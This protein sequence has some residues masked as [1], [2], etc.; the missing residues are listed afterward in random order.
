MTPLAKRHPY[1]GLPDYQFWKNEPGITDP[2]LFDPINTTSFSIDPRDAIVTAGSCFAQHVARYLSASGFNF[3]VT[4]KCHPIFPAEVAAANNFNIFSAR[5]GNIY[6]V[7]QL[8]QLILRA[9][10]EFEPAEHAWKRSDGCFLDPFRPQI[11]RGGYVNLQELEA[12]RASHLRAVR[13]AFEQMAVF[14]FTL[15]LTETWFDRRDGAVFPLAPGV[16]GG[17][18]D[19]ERFAFQ[20][21]TVSEV[22]DDLQWCIDRIRTLNPRCRFIV[23]VS[24]VPLNATA[25]DRHVVL[26]TTLS[27]S[28]LRVAAEQVC[29][30]NEQ[31][32]Y[33]PSFEIITS[34]L[35]RGR[36][37]GPDCREISEEGVNHVMGVFMK[38]YAGVSLA[39]TSPVIAKEDTVSDHHIEN[40]QNL[41]QVLCDEEAIG[42]R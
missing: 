22:A 8:K 12:D 31:C 28:V 13:E 11:H 9:Y 17:V 25:V 15:G 14:V 2:A 20:N 4:E 35:T 24:P 5:Y 1:V 40:M 32:D 26:S 41:I 36:Y 42:N 39:P 21:F 10:G 30:A 29:G 38:H 6:T 33:F 16:V 23:T 34:S 27:K 19:P 37:F 3:L 18:Y 7:R